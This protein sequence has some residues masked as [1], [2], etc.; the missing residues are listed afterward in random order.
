MKNLDALLK[1]WLNRALLFDMQA[2]PMRKEAIALG[3]GELPA[4]C[5]GEPRAHFF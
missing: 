4:Y 5:L 1:A 2:K 3:I